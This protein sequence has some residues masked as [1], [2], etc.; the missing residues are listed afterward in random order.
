MPRCTGEQA[1]A[2]ARE[3]QECAGDDSEVIAAE[4]LVA[5]GGDDFDQMVIDHLVD[6]FLK[7]DGIDLSKD[8]MALQRL[9]EAAERAKH[10]LSVALGI[11][12]HGT[13]SRL[14]RLLDRIRKDLSD[15]CNSL[16]NLEHPVLTK[17]FHSSLLSIK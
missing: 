16:E 9:K 14:K 2:E 17:G 10:E 3:N 8:P 1:V 4:E 7:S 6:T 11:S 15:G 13:R 5:L 12:P